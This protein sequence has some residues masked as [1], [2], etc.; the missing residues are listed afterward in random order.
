MTIWQKI[1]IYFW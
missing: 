1:L